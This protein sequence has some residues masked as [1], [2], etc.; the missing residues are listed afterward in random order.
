M[1]SDVKDNELT[2]TIDRL[3][4][5]EVVNPKQLA[6]YLS[7][8]DSERKRLRQLDKEAATYVESVIC[9]RTDFTGETEETS[10]W[11]GLGAALTDALDERDA[12]R[13]EVLRLKQIAKEKVDRTLKE[14]ID[15]PFGVHLPSSASF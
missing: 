12:L 3:N 6:D 10:G 11:K 7:R 4:K 13:A 14:D 9:L 5:G 8:L 2:K 15:E 1:A